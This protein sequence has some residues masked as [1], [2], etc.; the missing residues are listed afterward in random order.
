M[1][2][3]D[4]REGF[5]NVMA[6]VIA[7]H[8]ERTGSEIGALSWLAKQFGVS[9]QTIDNYRKRKGF[10]SRYTKKLMRL[11]GLSE[12]E[13]WPLGITTEVNFPTKIW[14]S[15]ITQA[16]K[17]GRTGPETVV[18]LVRIGLKSEKP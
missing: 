2:M 1:G 7:Q 9:R 6:V 5:D 15:V 3:K 12:D 17:T 10:P 13:I 16:Q 11:T 8:K 4:F 14:D 18:E